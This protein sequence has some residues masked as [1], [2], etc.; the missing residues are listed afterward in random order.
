[1]GA[2]VV[3]LGA[4]GLALEASAF[5]P[6]AQLE[7]ACFVDEPG[8]EHLRRALPGPICTHVD[9]PA[10]VLALPALIAVGDPAL[11]A[12]WAAAPR[13]WTRLVH[14]AAWTAASVELAEGVI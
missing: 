14:P 1:M 4:G 3:V 13:P 7:I 11:R 2:R 5:C 8:F 10:D 9:A 12:R 6:G